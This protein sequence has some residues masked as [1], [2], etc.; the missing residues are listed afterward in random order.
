MEI[1]IIQTRFASKGAGGG[2]IHT[3]NLARALQRL[4]HSVVIHTSTPKYRRPGIS[5]L[6][7]IEYQVPFDINPIAEIILAQRAFDATQ[8][9]DVALLTDGSAWRAVDLPIPTV[10]VF[11]FVWHG[12]C[13]RHNPINDILFKKPQSLLYR[14]MENKIAEKSDAI[15]SISPGMKEDIRRIAD[16]EEKIHSIPNGVDVERFHPVDERYSEFTVH[17]QGRLVEMKNPGVLI[18]AVA[19]SNGTWRVTIGGDGPLREDLEKRAED[20]EVGSRIEFLGYVPDDELPERYAKSDVYVL[21]SSYEGMPLTVLEAAA[22]GTPVVASPRAATDFVDSEIGRVVEPEPDELAN[23][24]DDLSRHP[25]LVSCLGENAR[26]R[27]ES[28]SWSAIAEKYESLFEALV[29]E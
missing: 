4:G 21:P 5:D 2:E 9:S 7:I 20:L 16:I 24:L 23:V 27:A 3:E 1:S 11:H 25:D 10:M 18:D 26:S 22:S 19:K 14:Q 8:A 17:F 12:W 6:K 28:Y 13:N 15:I 29:K